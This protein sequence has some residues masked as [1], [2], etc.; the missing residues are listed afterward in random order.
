MKVQNHSLKGAIDR[1][2]KMLMSQ[3]GSYSENVQSVFVKRLEMTHE[4]KSHKY[5]F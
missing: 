1:S 4:M 2:V 3:I 5:T